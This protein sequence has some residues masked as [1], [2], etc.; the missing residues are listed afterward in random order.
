MGTKSSKCIADEL[1]E[2]IGRSL[3]LS[4]IHPSAISEK[5]Y[6]C[7]LKCIH[8]SDERFQKL[9]TQARKACYNLNTAT[10]IIKLLDSLFIDDIYNWG[11]VLIVYAFTRQLAHSYYELRLELPEINK[12]INLL[13]EIVKKYVAEKIVP[14]IDSDGGGWDKFII[15]SRDS[16][17]GKSE[18][19][20]HI[21]GLIIGFVI[22]G[23]VMAVVLNN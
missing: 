9:D 14:W 4:P 8:E 22:G 15:F 7:M 20:M 12:R 16:D 21:S 1:V 2:C 13:I 6:Y 23:V 5:Y 3:T 18:F 10:D 11:R 17:I 19:R